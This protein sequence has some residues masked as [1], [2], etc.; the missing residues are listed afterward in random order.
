MIYLEFVK[1]NGNKAIFKKV[2]VAFYIL[3][4]STIGYL[5]RLV[6]VKGFDTVVIKAPD[7]MGI[8]FDTHNEHYAKEEKWKS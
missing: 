4:N 7:W 8:K 5:G 3:H 6:N 1:W 2:N